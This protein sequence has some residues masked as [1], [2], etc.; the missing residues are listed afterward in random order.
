QGMTSQSGSSDVVALVS[1][2][3]CAIGYS[4]MAFKTPEVKVVKVAKEKG[5]PAIEP[6]LETALDGTYPISRPL[7]LYTLGE[8]SGAI[9]EFI[10]WVTGS[11]GQKI[12]EQEGYV[13]LPSDRRGS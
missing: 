10:Q 13:P 2:T 9:A 3:P 6:N 11:E 12:V 5:Q 4:G 8:T 7:Y 1:H